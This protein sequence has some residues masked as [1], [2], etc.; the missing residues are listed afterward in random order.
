MDG[1][2]VPAYLPILHTCVIIVDLYPLVN[3]MWSL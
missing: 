3:Y 2:N 1:G